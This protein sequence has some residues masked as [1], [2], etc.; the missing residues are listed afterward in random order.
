MSETP[1]KD[2]VMI[3]AAERIRRWQVGGVKITK[4]VETEM[5]R[6]VKGVFPN[7]EIET[8]DEP[9]WLQ[10]E[11]V[12]SDGRLKLSF[13]ALVIETQSRRIVVDTCFG[14]DKQR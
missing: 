4:I 3:P 14:N 10:S 13:H 8:L 9:E 7:A 1:F 5:L 2:I 12:S 6:S 11:F